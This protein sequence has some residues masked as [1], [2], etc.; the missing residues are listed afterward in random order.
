MVPLVNL[1]FAK[2]C[3]FFTGQKRRAAGFKFPE[4]TNKLKCYRLG[5][6]LEGES[7]E[8]ANEDTSKGP[9]T[10]QNSPS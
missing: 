6:V 2:H 1:L 8:E 9:I 3:N 5:M 10:K 4:T 7:H